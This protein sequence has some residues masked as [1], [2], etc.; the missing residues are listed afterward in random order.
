MKSRLPPRTWRFAIPFLLLLAVAG[1]ALAQDPPR[2]A[3]PPLPLPDRGEAVP[4]AGVPNGTSEEVP[5]PFP[6]PEHLRHFDFSQQTAEEA[7]AKSHGCVN[8]HQSVVDPHMRR[9]VQLGC[10]DCHGGDPH[11]TEKHAAHVPPRHPD[12]WTSSGNPV[13][14]YTL[15]NRESP[16]FIR[17]VNPGD[18]RVAHI[19]CGQCHQRDTLAVKK[20]MMTHGCMLWGAALYNN[21]AVPF[22]WPRFGE[23]YSMHGTPQRLQT[24]PPPTPEETAKKGILPFLD[25]LPRYQVSQP[26]NVLRVFERGGRFKLEIGIPETREEPG[27]PRSRLSNRGLG[28]LS[29]TDPTML[30]LQKTRLLDPTLNFLGTNDHPGDYRSSGCTACHMIYANDRS[31]VHAGPYAKYGNLGRAAA[32]PDAWVRSIDPMIPKHESG[33]PIQH[34]FTNAIPTS[35]CISC[36]IHP[37]TNVMNSYLGYMWWDQETEGQHMYPKEAK[38]L[39]AEE[40]TQAKMSNPNEGA[41]RGNWSDPEF[42]L[43]TPELNP[44]LTKTQFADFHGH[45]WVFR[46]VF[47]K[48]REGFLLDRQGR[49][50]K[51]VDSAKLMQAVA[52]PQQV[53]KLHRNRDWD[54]QEDMQRLKEL[55][56]QLEEKYKNVPVHMLDIH[57]EKGMH[58]IDCHFIQDVH[59][60]TKLYGEVRAAIEITCRDCHGDVDRRAV[61]VDETG[62]PVMRTTGPAANS[63]VPRRRGLDLLALTTPSGKRRFELHGDRIIQ[64]SMVEQGVS[65]E[66]SQVAD[67]LNPQHD[68]YNPLSAIAKTVRFERDVQTRE[69]RLAWGDVPPDSRVCAHSSERVSCIACH[70]S[71]NQSCYGCH[72][73]QKANRKVP[74]LHNEGDITRNE[75]A[76]NFQTLRDEV[77]MLA[78]DGTVTG[79]R[80]GPARSSC[81]IHVSSYNQNRESIYIQQQTI[82]ADGLSGIAFSTNVPHTVRGS[83]ETKGCTD[84]H[85][86]ADND[87][88]AILAQ[89]LMHGTNYLN[90]IGH[91]CWVATGEHGLFGVPVTEAEEPQAVLGSTLHQLAFPDKFHEHL[92]NQGFLEEAH[93]HP[94]VDIGDQLRHPFTKHEVLSAQ[95]RG[96]FLYAAC[97]EAGVRVYDVAN[98]DNKAFSERIVTAPFSPAGQ[99]N[100]VRTKNALAVAAPTTIAPDPT[101]KQHPENEEPAIHAI[102]AY[103]YVADAEEGLILIN[104]GTLL[105]GLP[106]NNFLERALTF[107]PDGL[108]HGARAVTIVGTYAYVCCDVGLVVISLEDPLHPVVTSVLDETVLR[109]PTDVQVQFRYAFVCHKDGVT[110]LDV[111]ELGQPR[112]LGRD[113]TVPLPEAKRIYVARTYAY[114]AAGHQGLVI[115]DVKN[116]ERPKMDQIYD[117]N[118]CINDLHDVKL[119][120]TYVSEFAY[121]A[122]GH[123]GLRIVQLT[124]PE[125][126]GNYGFSP[127]PTPRLIATYKIPDEG[128][129]LAISEGVD[130]DRAVDEA[131]N[132]IAV[133]GR[134]GARPLNFQEQRRLYQRPGTGQV[135][136][137]PNLD[138]YHQLP[139]A[140]R[141]QWLLEQFRQLT[142][143]PAPVQPRPRR[144]PP[145]DNRR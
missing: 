85:L 40:F 131:G 41:A 16:E 56:Q 83:G 103:I 92:E 98:I 88:N 86:S 44:L 130:R 15:L 14:S 42:L 140:A 6:I 51:P 73:P 52:L 46:A 72:L 1:S 119:G 29:R 106:T 113:A 117:A 108:L 95:L 49:R 111:T 13:R 39:T 93:E 121:L 55:S 116:P 120:I 61:T 27:R 2:A 12:A 4:P 65:W 11:A 141:H 66:V 135:W 47:K 48:D 82:S 118:G 129:A 21:G 68:D 97:G 30:G 67:T 63:E 123:N 31:P 33:H 139:K 87:N 7:A 142:A 84:C 3:D 128:E 18:L 17:F 28:T 126:P 22:K 89:L 45:G 8:C 74:D 94:G 137:V 59:G 90:F 24:V 37:G 9:T 57:L 143:Q 96:E 19:S 25:P 110:V 133:F 99:R 109:K 23:S 58:C 75:I 70:S 145:G 69:D 53:K 101:R 54:S 38:H 78:K 43:R 107:N 79:Q 50:V 138:A 127:R 132:Q 36:H 136:K 134:V 80:I 124:S 76:Y 34:R 5:V 115:L 144:Y 10:I 102:Y 91:Y 71:W 81:A 77:Y 62:R 60:N 32:E 20:S 26:G 100:Y 122:D 104:V 114:V 105:D 125:T 112:P 64:N 35:Q